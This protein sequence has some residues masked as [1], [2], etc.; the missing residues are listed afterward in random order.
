MDETIYGKCGY[1]SVKW[2]FRKKIICRKTKRVMKNGR[3]KIHRTYNFSSI[4]RINAG[5]HLAVPL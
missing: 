5:V 1:L 3:R 4:F 2:E